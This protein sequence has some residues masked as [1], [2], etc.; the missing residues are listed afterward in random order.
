LSWRAK[1]ESDN[2]AIDCS[3]RVRCGKGLFHPRALWCEIAGGQPC[4]LGCGPSGL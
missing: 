3:K 4:P 1:S 2:W